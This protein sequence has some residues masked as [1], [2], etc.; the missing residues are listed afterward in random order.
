MIDI[1]LAFFVLV[2]ATVIPASDRGDANFARAL[3][4]R[5][6]S[7]G[8]PSADPLSIDSNSVAVPSQDFLSAISATTALCKEW[9][10]NEGDVASTAI[11][12]LSPPA[13]VQQPWVWTTRQIT[14]YA[15]VRVVPRASGLPMFDGFKPKPCEQLTLSCQVMLCCHNSP[16]QR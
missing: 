10:C 3:L 1:P 6:A 11:P 13:Q 16:F 5:V 7:P 12:G 15:A 9:Y 4:N 14:M 8:M 2:L